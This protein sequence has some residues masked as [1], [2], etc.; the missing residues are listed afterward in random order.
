M[1]TLSRQFTYMVT[2]LLLFS[3]CSEA[4]EKVEYIYLR[5][6]LTPDGKHYIYEYSRDGAFVTSNEISGRRLIRSSETF[7]ENAGVDVYGI[8]DHWSKDTLV[9]HVHHQNYVY[10]TDTCVIKTEYES[11]DGIIIK[12]IYEQPVV[13]GGISGD[14]EFDSIKVDS[15]RIKFA[16]LRRKFGDP[17]YSNREL[18][19]SLGEVVVYSDSGFVTKIGIDKQYKSMDFSRI[20][21]SG[22]KLF[23][24]PEVLINSYEFKPRGKIKLNSIGEIGIFRDFKKNP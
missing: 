9:I 2:F 5:R 23:H 6:Q 3:S 22:K 17:K 8:I 15:N 11:Y 12:R 4:P 24:Q 14:F 7:K 21:G 1:K 16:G 10:P 18:S 19:F 13:G 20:D